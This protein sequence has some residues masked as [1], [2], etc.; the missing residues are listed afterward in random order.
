MERKLTVILA[1]DVAGYSRLMEADEEATARIIN[2][3]REI[4]DGLVVSHHG[5]VFGSAGDSVIAEFASPV[6]TVRCAVAIQ[7]DLEAQNVDLPEDRRMRLRIG[8]NL[9]DVIVEGDNLLGDGVNIAARLEALAEP[10][11]ISLARSVFDQVKKQL[12]L[13]YEYLGEHKVK[14]IADPVQAYKVLL[15][16]TDIGK[17]PS[18]ERSS[19]ARRWPLAIGLAAL[20]IVGGAIAYVYTANQMDLTP[21]KSEKMAL[22]LPDKPSI[23]VLPFSNLSGDAGQDHLVEGITNAVRTHLSKFPQLLVIAG[24]TAVAF[25]DKSVRARDIGRELGVRYVLDGS[26]NRGGETLTVNAELIEAENEHTVWAEQYEFTVNDPFSVQAELVREIAG[27]M[28]FVMEEKAIAAVQRHPT[29]SPKAYDLYLRAMAE[30]QSLSTDGRKESIRLLNQAIELDPNFLAAHFE[31]SG[32]YLSLWRFGGADDPEK[33]LRLARRHAE[34]A[35]QLDRTD[36]RGI[37]RLGMLHLFADHEHELAYAAFRRALDKNPNDADILH[38]MG[39]LRSLMGEGAEAI[40]WNNKVKRINPRYPGWY[41]FNAALSHFWVKDYDQALILSKS[42]MA[43][44]PKSL[45]P[46]RILIVSLV[47]MGQIE[48]AKKQVVEF[49][50]IGPDFRLSTFRNTPFQHEVDQDRYFNALRRA[51]IPD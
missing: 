16:P 11:G 29:E 36:Y 25:K 9:G 10:G 49:L 50:A 38:D 3:Y 13:G 33:A 43:A 40:V 12:D 19:G 14:N 34:R 7:R 45:A 2:K 20:L 37:Y 8:I 48:E 46:R 42:A 18:A 35:L 1:A 6:E 24:T 31:L 5:R 30:S 32:R 28:R 15:D 22:P 41:N 39:F 47:E 23:V 44:Y 27:T 21:V 17:L 26:F 4:I 51:G